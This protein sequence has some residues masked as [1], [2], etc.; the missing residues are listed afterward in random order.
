M[1]RFCGRLLKNRYNL[2]ITLKK[3]KTLPVNTGLRKTVLLLKDFENNISDGRQIDYI[4][5]LG[6]L[7]IIEDYFVLNKQ[8]LEYSENVRKAFSVDNKDYSGKLIRLRRHALNTLRHS[9]LNSLGGHWADWDSSMPGDGG[10]AGFPVFSGAAVY[11]DG[12]RS[13]FNVGSIFRTSLAY[14][15]EKIFI[16]P[17]CASPEHPRAKRSSMGASEII[18][19]QR[20]DAEEIKKISEGKLFALELGGT[21]I[22]KFSFPLPGILVIGSEEVGVSPSLLEKAEQDGGIASIELPGPKASLNVGVAFGIALRQW[23]ENCAG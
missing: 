22:G 18:E 14:G 10:A 6:L 8:I 2:L 11:L 13:P 21:D 4:Y 9:I 5:L 17:D 20:A 19:W 12:I 15:I 1:N 3:L 7:E 23:K 16:S